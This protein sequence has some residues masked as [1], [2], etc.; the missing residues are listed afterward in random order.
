MWMKTS[1][2]AEYAQIEQLSPKSLA[3]SVLAKTSD[4]SDSA[5]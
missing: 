5:L 4:K 3:N 1:K 2:E